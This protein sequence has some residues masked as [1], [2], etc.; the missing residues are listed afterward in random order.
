M[1]VS[2]KRIRGIGLLGAGG[3]CGGWWVGVV[4]G[5]VALNLA[6]LPAHFPPRVGSP[7]LAHLAAAP[8]RSRDTRS[9]HAS[10]QSARLAQHPTCEE[11]H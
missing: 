8:E 2:A 5:R 10:S 4:V 6:V 7:A 11:I 9:G 3:G 1:F